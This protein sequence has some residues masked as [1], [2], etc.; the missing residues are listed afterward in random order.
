MNHWLNSLNSHDKG[1]RLNPLLLICSEFKKRS[2]K[3]IT[4]SQLQNFVS[5]LDYYS[6]ETSGQPIFQFRYKALPSGIYPI[7]LDEV[8]IGKV[9]FDWLC[10]K[11][12]WSIRI[13][14]KNLW[15]HI[16]ICENYKYIR[17]WQK[18]IEEDRVE[19]NYTDMFPDFF[20]SES[21]S[22]EEE[23]FEVW[24]GMQKMSK[25]HAGDWNIKKYYNEELLNASK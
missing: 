8:P 2:N 7:E 6:I 18:A 9:D 12:I 3:D 22:L 11:D 17:S 13:M 16:D 19:M 25:N 4:L 23:H 10:E 5:L 14:V 20:K 1:Q 15:E 21:D 24:Y